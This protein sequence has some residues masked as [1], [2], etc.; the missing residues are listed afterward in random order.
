MLMMLEPHMALFVALTRVGKTHLALD[1]LEREYLNH[2]DFIVI[3]CPILKYNATYKSRKW[4]NTDP[5]IIQIELGHRPYNWIEK[6]G[7]FLAASKILFLIDDII[8]DETLDKR[9]QPLLDLAMVSEASKRLGYYSQRK[10]CYRTRRISES[11]EA[12]ET[13]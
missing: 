6:L 9:R 1:L 11:Q 5:Y 13:G 8:T 4:F 2:F 3:L 7:N 12:D 10:R